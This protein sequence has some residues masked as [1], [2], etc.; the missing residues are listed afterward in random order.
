MPLS[1]RTQWRLKETVGGAT[2]LPNQKLKKT[3]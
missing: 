3:K 2:A 1:I